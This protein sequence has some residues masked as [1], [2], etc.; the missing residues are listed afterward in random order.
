VATK[1]EIFNKK[2]QSYETLTLVDEETIQ[3]SSS[4]K[5]LTGENIFEINLPLYRS[6]P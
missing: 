3:T 6:I 5:T 2:T 1:V 4:T